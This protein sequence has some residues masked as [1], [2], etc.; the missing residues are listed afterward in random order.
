MGKNII[1]KIKGL[2]RRLLKSIEK[3]GINSKKTREI[4]DEMDKLIAQY[5]N[6][7]KQVDYSKESDMLE[8]YESSYKALKEITEQNNKFPIVKEWNKYAKDN[9]YLSNVSIEYISKLKWNYLRTK[10]L[11]ELNM[12]I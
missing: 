5:Y 10:V 11:R 6:S 7:I 1:I 8:Y 2:R 12:K 3:N 4:S 9:Y